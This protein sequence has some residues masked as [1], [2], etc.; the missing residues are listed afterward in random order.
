MELE[1]FLQKL[2][3][4]FN[5]PEGWSWNAFPKQMERF[6]P[7]GICRNKNGFEPW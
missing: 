5:L 1:K 7:G 3:F 4:I 6:L 2:K